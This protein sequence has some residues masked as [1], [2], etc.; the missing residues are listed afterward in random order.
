ME[1]LRSRQ[2]ALRKQQEIG[3]TIAGIAGRLESNNPSHVR[4]ARLELGD[5]RDPLAIG[6]LTKAMQKASVANRVRLLESIGQIQAPEASYA[7]AITAAIDLSPEVRLAAIELMRARPE[8]TARFVPVLEQAL[9]SEKTGLVYNAADALEGL[10][11]RQSVPHL[12]DA[13]LTPSR[14]QQSGGITTSDTEPNWVGG[15][16]FTDVW[17]RS[18]SVPIRAPS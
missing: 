14:N 12:I 2:E 4:Q 3:Q 5:I 9:R 16:K 18:N 6:P 10:G 13:L 15:L 17:A 11:Q 1:T 8:D 7:L